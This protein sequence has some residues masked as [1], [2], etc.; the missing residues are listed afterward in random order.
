MK[1]LLFIISTSFLN[2]LAAEFIYLNHFPIPNSFNS[3]D[4]QNCTII[5]K[6]NGSFVWGSEYKNWF[7]A[8][9]EQRK[10]YK[11]K[12]SYE[13]NFETTNILSEKIVNGKTVVDQEK[14]HFYIEYKN[15]PNSILETIS[16]DG[17]QLFQSGVIKYGT[18]HVRITDGIPAI[19]NENKFSKQ[20]IFKRI[21]S[22]N[23]NGDIISTNNLNIDSTFSLY[24]QKTKN[25]ERIYMSKTESTIVKA[26]FVEEG[27]QKFVYFY[28]LKPKYT[29]KGYFNFNSN[30][31]NSIRGDWTAVNKTNNGLNSISFKDD[32]ICR[33]IYNQDRETN[34]KMMFYNVNNNEIKLFSD[35][36]SYPPNEDYFEFYGELILSYKIDKNKLFL[37]SASETNEFTIK[38]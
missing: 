34:F 14:S 28:A 38:N 10:G 11:F 18:A 1:Y 35:Y 13:I 24:F 4:F 12:Y 32:G 16:I 17:F 19:I 21:I 31:L 6:P 22:I 36:K 25:N 30:N 9:N 37:F 26:D 23:K 29:E 27:G 20:T 5:T 7:V 2:I 3:F 15:D 33:M 8:V